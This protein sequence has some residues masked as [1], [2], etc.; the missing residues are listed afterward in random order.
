MRP[1]MQGDVATAARALIAVP[2]SAR[3]AL[4]T[5]IVSQAQAADRYR[6]REGRPHPFWG[7]GSLMQAA[8]IRPIGA[9]RGTD[10]PD[11]ADCLVE[12]LDALAACHSSGVKP[13]LLRRK[14]RA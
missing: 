10:D 12:V 1:V 3:K 7:N 11:F 9:A 6:Q 13:I 14:C 8:L 2:P 4:A 5:R